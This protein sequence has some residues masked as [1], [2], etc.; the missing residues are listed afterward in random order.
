MAGTQLFTY[1]ETFRLPE[2]DMSLQGSTQMELASTI[3]MLTVPPGV[4]VNEE[5]TLQEG[6][7]AE[8]K[9]ENGQYVVVE[10]HVDEYGVGGSL[11]EAQQDLFSSLVDY[12][13]SLEKRE[14]RLGD[15]DRNILSILRNMLVKS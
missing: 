11:Q 2:I 14:N 10:Y 12:L 15:K 8:V 6:L 3:G 1:V 4:R 7:T 5:F 9:V 13:K